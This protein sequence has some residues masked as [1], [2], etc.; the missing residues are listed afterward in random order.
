[1]GYLLKKMMN[2]LTIKEI[3]DSLALYIHLGVYT[4]DEIK[5]LYMLMHRKLKY[6]EKEY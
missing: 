1:M 5:E 6:Y 4:S 2:S 3:E